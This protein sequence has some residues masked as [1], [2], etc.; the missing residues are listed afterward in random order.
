MTTEVYETIDGYME[1]VNKKVASKERFLA[2][3]TGS[4]SEEKSWCHYCD[5]FRD[6]IKK[7]VLQDSKLTVLKGI[8]N[9]KEEWVGV[10]DHPWKQHRLLRPSGVPCLVLIE[11]DQVLHK[12]EQGLLRPNQ[13]ICTGHV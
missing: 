11:H 2:Y 12:E 3:M 13:R 6:T 9:T 10:K 5:L 1:A 8:V 4:K 7:N